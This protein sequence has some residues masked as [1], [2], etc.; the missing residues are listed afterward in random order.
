MDAR[1]K[2]M[3]CQPADEIPHD[4]EQYRLEP[5][6]DGWRTIMVVGGTGVSIFGG[7]NA[8]D[9]TGKLPYI[10]ESLSSVLPA[11]TALDGELIAPAGWGGVQGTMTR[12]SGAHVPGPASP[13]LT[14]VVFDVILLNG[15]DVRSM[16]Y[17][18]RRG[19]L[20][21]V[22]WPEHTHLTPSGP[23]TADAHIRMIEAGM[24]GSVCK[25]L[26]SHY[27]SGQRSPL[28]RKL[29]AIDSDDCEIVGFKDGENGRSG[30]VGAIVVKLPSGVETT[31]S[32]MTDKVRADMLAHPEKYLGKTVEIKHNGH[33]ESGKVRH[34]RFFRMREDR[35]PAPAPA[36]APA[37]RPRRASSGAW[38]RNYKAMGNDK[39]ATSVRQLAFKEG[40]A[41]QRVLDHGANLDQHRKVA[42]AEAELR[43]LPVPA[44]DTP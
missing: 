43:G 44:F 11:D 1:F 18:Q 13:A 41:Y 4:A 6:F 25:R 12:G 29:K 19:L 24:E 23:A 39:L 38:M 42:R 22:P 17:E 5:K 31:A 8:S 40:D 33:L 7:R 16:P 37:R 27:A 32:G 15:S 10:T 30:E 21:M 26:D 28:W 9:Y 20:Q 3:L 36:P 2:P 14:F 35:D 34:P